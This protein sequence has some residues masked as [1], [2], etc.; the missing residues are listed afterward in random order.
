MA[1]KKHNAPPGLDY[2]PI[3]G[4]DPNVSYGTVESG[5]AEGTPRRSLEDVI[6]PRLFPTDKP[7]RTLPWTL[8]TAE[9][10][11]V[12]LPKAAPDELRDP[13]QLSRAYHR[14]RGEKI[15][16]L[17][18]IVSIRF[19]EADAAPPLLRLHDAWE[20]SRGFGLQL[21]RLLDVAVVACMHVPGRSW[22]IG[23]PHV[24]LI[25]PS[26]SI[27]PST[28]F[29]TFVMELINPAEGRPLIDTT[30]KEWREA[31]GYGD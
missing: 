23:V 9:R 7:D 3:S 13:Q 17:A 11:D 25:C 27:R 19:P 29:S 28:G 14:V 20:L 26:R 15:Q 4:D 1:V 2:D 21:T 10:W 12:L 24:H 5:T 8:P 18:T 6:F 31:A 16:H 22:G 30:W